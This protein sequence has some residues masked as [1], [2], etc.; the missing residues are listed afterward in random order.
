MLQIL[1]IKFE[2][3]LNSTPRN[4][5]IENCMGLITRYIEI[6]QGESE[7]VQLAK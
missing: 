5:P 7:I 2:C 1:C 6:A 4:L 3:I